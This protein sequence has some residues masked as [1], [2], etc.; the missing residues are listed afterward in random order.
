MIGLLKVV[1]VEPHTKQHSVTVLRTEHTS[2]SKRST[3]SVPINLISNKS[4]QRSF[5]RAIHI[6]WVWDSL[7]TGFRVQSSLTS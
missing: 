5:F 7:I 3:F 6:I 2:T 4:V 1:L